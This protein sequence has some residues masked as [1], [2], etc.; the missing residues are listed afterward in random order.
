MVPV[1][2]LLAALAET[3]AAASALL[4]AAAM[5]VATTAAHALHI[6]GC[7]VRTLML[8]PAGGIFVLRRLD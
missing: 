7:R 5:T 3:A 6:H 4:A 1:H 8:Q 2:R